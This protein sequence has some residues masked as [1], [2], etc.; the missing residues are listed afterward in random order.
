MQLIP[1]SQSVGQSVSEN[2]E[3]PSNMNSLSEMDFVVILLTW[4][5]KSGQMWK[6]LKFG[7]KFGYLKVFSGFP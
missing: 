5:L 2:F 1:L 3:Q 4:V 7:S 6:V